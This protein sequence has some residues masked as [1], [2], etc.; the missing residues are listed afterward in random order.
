[1]SDQGA[2]VGLLAGFRGQLLLLFKKVLLGVNYLCGLH[3]CLAELKAVQHVNAQLHFFE[4][5]Q[6][7][8]LQTDPR[9]RRP[10]GSVPWCYTSHVLSRS[11]LVTS[12]CPAMW[13]VSCRLCGWHHHSLHACCCGG[14]WPQSLQPH[15]AALRPEAAGGRSTVPCSRGAAVALCCCSPPVRFAE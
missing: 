9:A 1:V 3:F 7:L 5:K 2:F 11:C 14:W 8:L 12:K 4:R 13:L 10:L 15:A 6:K